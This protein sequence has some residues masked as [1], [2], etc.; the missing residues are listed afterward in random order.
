MLIFTFGGIL[1]QT[2]SNL[3]RHPRRQSSTAGIP[4]VL[5]KQGPHCGGVLL[6]CAAPG[7]HTAVCQ[8]GHEPIQAHLPGNCGS[9]LRA[10]EAQARHRHAEGMCRG[11][12]E[13]ACYRAIW[14]SFKSVTS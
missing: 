3:I 14:D 11:R 1:L 12:S 13:I 6:R 9:E 2:H 5:R 10:G 7:P 4:G 8:R